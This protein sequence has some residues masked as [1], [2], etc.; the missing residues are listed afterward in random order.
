MQCKH[1]GT[2]N[3]RV[4]KSWVQISLS[5]DYFMQPQDVIR[6]D[7][8]ATL[9]GI[10]SRTGSRTIPGIFEGFSTT[11][12]GTTSGGSGRE[13][14]YERY[15]HLYS[16]DNFAR[17]PWLT[18]GNLKNA[19]AIIAREEWSGCNKSFVSSSDNFASATPI[20]PEID[21]I[22]PMRKGEGTRR[23]TEPQFLSRIPRRPINYPSL[24]EH[25]LCLGCIYIRTDKA[26]PWLNTPLS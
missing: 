5:R 21:E 3:L 18:A 9:R 6:R 23:N 8:A 11:R 12:W 25:L 15:A 14:A 1:G 4:A 7:D 19:V 10:N 20:T 26:A 2:I 16:C 24:A 13:I 17:A 22:S